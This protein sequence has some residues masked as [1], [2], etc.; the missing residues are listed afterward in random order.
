M[1]TCNTSQA[2]KK[3]RERGNK[4]FAAGELELAIAT[5]DQAISLHPS[6]DPKALAACFSNRAAAHLKLGSYAFAER[7]ASSALQLVANDTEASAVV[8]QLKVLYRRATARKVCVC[9]YV[10]YYIQHHQIR[11]IVGDA[12]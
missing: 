6:P 4:F 12:E 2:I 5:Y 8:L 3:V 9:V 7:D 10:R 11:C 1:D